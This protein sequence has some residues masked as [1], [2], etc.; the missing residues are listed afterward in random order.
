MTKQNSNIDT[1]KAISL[2]DK[3][4]ARSRLSSD[5]TGLPL[6]IF[7]LSSRLSPILNVDLLIKDEHGRTLLAWRDD[8]FAGQGWHVPGGVVRFKEKMIDRV[9]EVARTEI[10]QTV[11]VNPFPLTH[12]EVFCPQNTRGHFYS[13]LYGCLL[14]NSYEPKNDKFKS[15]DAGYLVWHDKCPDNLIEVH[16]VYREFI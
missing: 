14:S 9:H 11:H 16:E 2:I 12:N 15:T 7:Y 1:E 3:E 13:V 8:E 5:Y 6:D 4:V 10:G